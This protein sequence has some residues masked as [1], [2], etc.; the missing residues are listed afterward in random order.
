MI[1][2]RN[3]RNIVIILGPV[4]LKYPRDLRFGRLFKEFY[5]SWK[6]FLNGL[7]PPVV[8]FFPVLFRAT[9]KPLLSDLE[10]KEILRVAPEI[11][12][13]IKKLS[14]AR[15]EHRELRH[16]EKHIGFW[17]GKVVFIDFDHGRLSRRS[18]DLNKFRAWLEGIKKSLRS[19]G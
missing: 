18:R 7:G 17:R 5:L 10:R 8:L 11:E 12:K 19:A 14:E 15:I 9:V 1:K 16:P 3:A 2:R 6:A 4:V 13:A